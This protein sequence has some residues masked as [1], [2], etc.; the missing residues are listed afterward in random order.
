MAKIQKKPIESFED[1]C[2]IIDNQSEQDM[3]FL[4]GFGSNKEDQLNRKIILSELEH[5]NN[6]KYNCFAKD[7]DLKYLCGVCFSSVIYLLIAS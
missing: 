5:E 1:S 2:T 7:F 6:Q 3:Y 4:H